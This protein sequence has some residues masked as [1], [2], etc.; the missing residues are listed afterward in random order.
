MLKI[1]DGALLRQPV[2]VARKWTSSRMTELASGL[3]AGESYVAGQLDDL[4]PGMHV[5][6][7]EN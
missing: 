1:A 3:A 2:E 7:V 6:V 4:K 5:T